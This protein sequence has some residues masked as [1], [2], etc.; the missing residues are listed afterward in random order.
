MVLEPLTKP[1]VSLRSL[2]CVPALSP[3]FPP[4]SSD[5]I[6]LHPGVH[7][8]GTRAGWR[9]PFSRPHLPVAPDHHLPGVR[10]RRL[11]AGPAQHPAALSGQRVCP[12]QPGGEDLA[13]C[14]EQLYWS[15]EG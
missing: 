11:A 7:S 2:L 3:C 12:V 1:L 8:D 10:P 6:I 15:C 9:C 13:L 5:H 4:A 14:S